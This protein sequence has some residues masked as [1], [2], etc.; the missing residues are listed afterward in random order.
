MDPLYSLHAVPDSQS[1]L[2]NQRT[3]GTHHRSQEDAVYSDPDHT[4]IILLLFKVEPERVGRVEIQDD[5]APL[6]RTLGILSAH[7]ASPWL[8]F[9]LIALDDAFGSVGLYRH[10]G[11]ETPGL[12]KPDEKAYPT[13]D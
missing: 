2:E 12:G 6:G 5:S 3:D 10:S 7:L 13:D 9:D 11:S 4:S 8:F 1:P